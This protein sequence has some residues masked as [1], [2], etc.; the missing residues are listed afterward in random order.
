MTE[1]EYW[2]AACADRDI[3][4]KEEAR[5][6]AYPRSGI[7]SVE[8]EAADG[9]RETLFHL[10]VDGRFRYTTHSKAAAESAYK[11]ILAH[12]RSTI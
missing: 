10:F 6:K 5:Y 9:T 11:A 4:I 8:A 1:F 12:E 3:Q 7:Y 2:A